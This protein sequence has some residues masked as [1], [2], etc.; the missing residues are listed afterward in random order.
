MLQTYNQLHNNNVI[1]WTW[2]V[3]LY[4]TLRVIDKSDWYFF[5]FL[6]DVRIEN[7]RPDQRETTN[8]GRVWRMFGAIPLLR[9]VCDRRTVGTHALGVLAEVA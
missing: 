9:G 1:S 5:V 6:F 2:L 4:R 8:I 3:A 7:L